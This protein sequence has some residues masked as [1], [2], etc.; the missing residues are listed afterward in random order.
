MHIL[1]DNFKISQKLSLLLN[2]HGMLF[3]LISLTVV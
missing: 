3:T 1:A 2:Q